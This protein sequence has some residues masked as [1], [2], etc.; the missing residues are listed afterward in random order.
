MQ[1]LQH[2]GLALATALAGIGNTLILLAILGNRLQGLLWK[3]LGISLV[4]TAIALI[5]LIAVSVWIARF[6]LWQTTGQS[7]EKIAWLSLALVAST[8]G[9]FSV[10]HAF[11]SEELTHL[12]LMLRRKIRK[13][14]STT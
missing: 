14:S 8:I 4:R 13:P 12:K 9:Y 7:L 3:T 10:H 6:P 11:K 1:W 5:P 2:T